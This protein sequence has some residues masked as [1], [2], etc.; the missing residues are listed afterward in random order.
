MQDYMQIILFVWPFADRHKVLY[1]GHCSSRAHWMLAYKLTMM[2]LRQ[3]QGDADCTGSCIADGICML[4]RHVITFNH[5]HAC[6]L[7]T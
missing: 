3:V 6:N 7:P 4:L 2:Q 1:N 5:E